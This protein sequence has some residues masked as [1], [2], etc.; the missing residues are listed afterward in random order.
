MM[1]D[2]TIRTALDLKK[3]GKA[4][5]GSPLFN[6]N[7]PGQ[8][9]DS[10]GRT[11]TWIIT[12]LSVGGVH[13]PYLFGN[14][15]VVQVNCGAEGGTATFN[16]EIRTTYDTPGTDVMGS[17]QVADS[18]GEQVTSFANPN[19]YAGSWFYLDISVFDPGTTELTVSVTAK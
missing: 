5:S 15:T 4:S 19:G 6:P 14:M 9:F 18:S 13:G 12:V 2:F 7:T 8:I 10:Q 11:F 16:V 1:P 17:D 3:V